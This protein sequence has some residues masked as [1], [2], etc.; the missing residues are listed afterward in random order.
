MARMAHIQPEPDPR[1]AQAGRFGTTHWSVVLAARDRD[2]PQAEQAL[3][4]LCEA[5]WYPLYAFVRRQGHDPDQAADL[6]QEFFARLL[7]KDY[8][9]AVDRTRG[10]FRSFLLAACTHFL[11][12]ERDR[13][14]AMR[15]GGG[16]PP[17][18]I[19]VRRAEG[20]YRAEPAHEL[21]AERLYQRRWALTLLDGVLERLGEESRRAGKVL[22]YQHLKVALTGAEGAVPYAR[23]GAELGM[24]EAAVK[25]AAERLRRR[26]REL[27]RHRIAETVADPA[28][29]DDEI[30]DLFAI[31]GPENRR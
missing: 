19:D 11:A 25:K 6:T 9:K 7:E 31:L 20:R 26:F 29:V 13:A 28:E 27:L 1:Q 15:R 17:V 24:S 10:R 5:Y 30:R 8:L 23:V 22:L 4:A 14:H 18:S 2:A 16:R 3:A 21:T 12:N